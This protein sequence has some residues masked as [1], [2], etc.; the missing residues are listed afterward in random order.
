[1]SFESRYHQLNPKQKQAVDTIYWPI[2]VI[3][4]P[5]S[6]KTELLSVR[7]ANI[8]RNTDASPNNILCLTFTDNAAKN[9][10]ERLRN[11]IG[12]DAYKVAI[13]TFHTFGMEILNRYQ[14]KLQE[15]GELTP[16]DDITASRIFHSILSSLPW[17]HPW[18]KS[19]LLRTLRSAISDLKSAGITPEDFSAILSINEQILND[20]CPIIRNSFVTIQSLGRKKEDLLQ[21]MELFAEMGTA[22]AHTLEQT[23]KAYKFQDTLATTLLNSI[24]AVIDSGD[25]KELTKWK[26][27]WLEK[28]SQRDFILKDVEKMK[29]SR[30]LLE[31]YEYYSAELQ[32]QSLIDFSDMILR[33]NRIIESDEIVRANLAEQYQWILIDEY[34]DTND[35]QLALVTNIAD[36]I[37]SPNIFA[38]GDDDQSIFKFQWASTRNLK[39]FKEHYPDTELIIL[40]TNYR[41]H[42][43]IIEF[44]RDI[45]QSEHRLEQL[46][47]N[48]HKSFLSHRGTGGSVETYVFDTE[49]EEIDYISR[50]I[51][52]IIEKNQGNPQFRL[53]DIAVITKKNATL[54]L[55][56]KALLAKHIPAELSKDENIFA[57]EVVMLIKNIL[58]YISSLRSGDDRDD[59]LI[60][61]LSHPMWGL[62][63]LELWELS[64]K[65][66]QAKKPENKTW[67]EVLRKNS[68]KKLKIIAHFFIDLSLR[69]EAIRLEDMIDLITGANALRLSEDYTDESASREQ[70]S[71]VFDGEA[72]NFTSPLYEYYFSEEKL[73]A[74]PLLYT[75]HLSNIRK[76]IE[77]LRTYKNQKPR[78]TLTDFVEY[79]HLIDEYEVT[80]SASSLITS[81]DAVQCITAHKSK[82]LEYDTVFAIGMTEKN[83]TRGMNSGNPFPSN[84]TLAPEKDN[85]EDIERLVYTICTRAKNR[86]I[87]SYAHKNLSEKSESPLSVLSHISEWNKIEQ[88][89]IDNCSFLLWNEHKSI[90][91]MPFTGEETQFLE[92]IITGHFSLSATAIQNFLNVADGW[93]AHYLSNNILRFPQAKSTA[94]IYGTAFHKALED[95]FK[96]YKI[97]K[98]FQKD[99]LFRS[100]QETIESEWL[101]EATQKELIDRG[102]QNLENLYPHLI[103]EYGE[104]HLEHRFNLE[105]GGTY[106]SDIRLTGAIDRIEITTDQTLIITDYKTG[107]GFAS[108]DE[109]GSSEYEKI[110]KW[111]YNLQLL[112]YAVLF[113]EAPRWAP[114]K[115]REFRLL[116]V[117]TDKKTG[118]YYEVTKFP[119]QGEIERMKRLIQAVAT[120]IQHLNF[121]DVSGYSPDISGIRQFEE[122]LLSGNI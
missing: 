26:N 97:R 55:I 82:G 85:T 109:T 98:T 16:I 6:G 72:E 30:G 28:S 54:E 76:L 113:E 122:D 90:I 4:G 92:S 110:K 61:I 80:L 38:V 74:K 49:L 119:Q 27:T 118:Q 59:L 52:Q 71:L 81:P 115:K 14:Y 111:K 100:F 94:N 89:S 21:K 68:N 19:S 46:F 95:F 41:S 5:G 103:R 108:L 42:Q 64:R 33:A 73:R 96:D 53:S 78:L 23:P 70:C 114:W 45:I 102:Y 105:G 104:I 40:D 88:K 117:E 13:H 79:I 69:S 24:H 22:I 35:A 67:I 10:R 18:K 83:Y 58:L 75:H 9:M 60:D 93:P 11:I 106:L 99:I 101:S 2:L 112:F 86:L 32:S 66:F 20:I 47:P 107:S 25:S 91:E 62:H 3:A 39:I 36:T 29:K 1:M 8:L 43:E 7:I 34:Q 63:R 51:A 15:D 87:L 50:E 48:A 77:S 37:D 57:N 31:I 120:R 116:F 84:L 44:S 17:D 121:P 65:I 12:A 56:A